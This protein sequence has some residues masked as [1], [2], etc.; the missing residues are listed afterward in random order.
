MNKQ[1][2][3]RKIEDEL[4]KIPHNGSIVF[5]EGYSQILNG[6]VQEYLHGRDFVNLTGV[7]L[8]MSMLGDRSQRSNDADESEQF[9]AIAQ[10]VFDE[11]NQ[12]SVREWL[13]TIPREQMFVIASAM[14]DNTII[15]YSTIRMF[16]SNMTARW[17]A[18][19][20]DEESI[21]KYPNSDWLP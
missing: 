11:N 13:K 12:A 8:M 6:Y 15:E 18:V 9:K 2:I 20:S 16:V 19:H 21:V 3:K 1:E 10:L 14:G 5:S 7:K 4:Y 17:N